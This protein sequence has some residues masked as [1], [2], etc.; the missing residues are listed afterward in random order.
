M[1]KDRSYLTAFRSPCIVAVFIILILTGCTADNSWWA[2]SMEAVLY[3]EPIPASTLT[4][5]A[6][7]TPKPTSTVLPDE[8]TADSLDVAKEDPVMTY[9]SS[10]GDDIS[11]QT[12]EDLLGVQVYR[13]NFC[14]T[15]HESAVA[16]TAGIFGP[17]HNDAGFLADAR[18]QD[19][20]YAGSATTAA[21]YI[22]ESLLDPAVYLV[23]GY[24]VTYMK[25]PPFTH[26]KNEDIEALVTFLLEQQ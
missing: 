13:E 7:D 17:S 6:V 26:L 5:S 18:M 21:E 11:G 16:Q 19:P 4:Q 23:P 25:M 10:R 2:G 3:E 12:D 8:T 15:C 1:D 24:E 9:S 20:D 22:R 14:G